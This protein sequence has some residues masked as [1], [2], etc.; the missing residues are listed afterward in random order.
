VFQAAEGGPVRAA[1]FRRRVW[2]PA[3]AAAGLE[4]LTF[5]GLRHSSVAFMVLGTHP[6]V[7]S[8]RLG[9]ADVRTTMGVYGNVLPEL[10]QA[11]GAALG[12]VLAPDDASAC[13]Q[14]VSKTSG[15]RRRPHPA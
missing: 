14:T 5:H 4:G 1:N 7:I 6:L 9:H 13:V 15:R 3:V 8:R 10:D 11:V 12:K 2:A